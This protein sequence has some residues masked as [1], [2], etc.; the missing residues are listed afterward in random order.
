MKS[1]GS[2]LGVAAAMLAWAGGMLLSGVSS[3]TLDIQ[4]KAKAAGFKA[5]N[6]QYCHVDKLP[7]KGASTGNERGTW[8][9]DQKEKK[10]AAEVDPAWL[11]DYPG[12]KA[13]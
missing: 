8:L 9:R 11:K 7:K 1:T 10:K 3:A 12:D 13:K 6:C 5:D 4:K 2:K